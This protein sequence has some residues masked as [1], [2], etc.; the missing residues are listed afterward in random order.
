MIFPVI[1]QSLVKL[2]IFF[3]LDVIRV[4]GP[5]RLGVVQFFSIGGLFLDGLLL[6]FLLVFFI[7]DFFDLRLFFIFLYFFS[8]FVVAN[9]LFNFLFNDEL[10]RIGDEFRVSLDDIL[11]LTFFKIFE[12]L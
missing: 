12:L 10:D 7:F 4:T 11:D 2:S 6:L 3:R 9:F 1:G 8:F 5:Q